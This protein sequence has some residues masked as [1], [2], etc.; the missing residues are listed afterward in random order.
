MPESV[1]PFGFLRHSIADWYCRLTHS[2]K[3]SH[4]EDHCV[5]CEGLVAKARRKSVS[6]NADLPPSSAK[7]RK[8]LELL[9]AIE[10]RGEREKTIIFSQFTSML[11]LIEPFLKEAGVKFVRCEFHFCLPSQIDY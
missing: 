1:R 9:D 4:D 11:D 10:E 2:N 6:V 5:S 7:I 3:S 8:I